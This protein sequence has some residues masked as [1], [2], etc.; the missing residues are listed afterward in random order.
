M[1]LSFL[2]IPIFRAAF[3][4]YSLL[5]LL[6]CGKLNGKPIAMH[7][8]GT[9]SGNYIVQ[10]T[11][12]GNR[13]D[14]SAQFN[15][16][17]TEL[18]RQRINTI[19]RFNMSS[20]VF[21][22][23]SLRFLAPVKFEDILGLRGVEGIWPV[24][25]NSKERGVI[26][27]IGFD[28]HSLRKRMASFDKTGVKKLHDAGITGKGVKVAI[29]DTGLD[30][31]HPA[32]G[33]QVGKGHKVEYVHDILDHTIHEPDHFLRQGPDK[34]GHGTH[35]AGIIAAQDKDIGFL[36][37][38]YEAT[39]RLYRVGGRDAYDEIGDD[40]IIRA[41]E[42][43]YD[44]GA[45]VICLTTGH[46]N[47]WGNN[48]VAVALSR[49]ASNG[50]FVSV[51]LGNSGEKGL[52]G[53]DNGA[54]A[55]HVI[56]VGAAV[57]DNYLTWEAAVIDG[58]EVRTIPVN[59]IRSTG[60]LLPPTKLLSVSRDPRSD[61]HACH[62]LDKKLDLSQY[63]VIIRIG[64]CGI[65]R[66]LTNIVARGAKAALFYNNDNPYALPDK[67]EIDRK[68]RIPCAMTTAD[69]GVWIM[70]KLN[71][72]KPL[73][74]DLVK[75]VYTGPHIK[76]SKTGGLMKMLSSWG[77]SND[78][79]I[80]P[81]IVAPGADIFST[82]PVS[83]GSYRTISGTSMAA[84]FIAGVAALYIS[85]H[86]KLKSGDDVIR[87]NNRIIASGKPIPWFDGQRVDPSRYAPVSQAGGGYIDAWQVVN[88]QTSISPGKI[89]LGTPASFDPK[90]KVQL[91]KVTIKNNGPVGAMY[92]IKHIPDYGLISI[93]GKQLSPPESRRAIAADLDIQ[94]SQFSL[95]PQESITLEL[96]FKLPP[97]EGVDHLAPIYSGRVHVIQNQQEDD[98][99]TIPYLG[100]LWNI[101]RISTLG[102]DSRFINLR[103]EKVIKENES[104]SM[105]GTDRPAVRLWL[106]W[107]SPEIKVHLVKPKWAQ[108]KSQPNYGSD[109]YVGRVDVN[110]KWI[111]RS[112][113]NFFTIKLDQWAIKS[114]NSEAKKVPSGDY[115]MVVSVLKPT[116]NPDNLAHWDIMES[117]VFTIK[118]Q[119]QNGGW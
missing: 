89:E 14:D 40:S 16:F 92:D 95:R 77:P 47:G 83:K 37:V 88:G 7:D 12:N 39:L 17:Y 87:L 63:V 109:N 80:K 98:T 108:W 114:S 84:P 60:S 113:D 1:A 8:A 117:P 21:T 49:I 45:H 76:D 52:F 70:D 101:D 102:K 54:A 13:K 112:R 72:G 28:D 32:L 35:V 48:A 106:V 79:R 69:V 43:A 53:I 4:F 33:G 78:F 20:T 73:L 10:F 110:A 56:G 59:N 93:D 66:Q 50:V 11:E 61:L 44:D 58:E 107:G 74:I 65:S 31:T 96:R 57:S 15:G 19:S 103:T 24:N 86:G 68:F 97:V 118:Y 6:H 41:A 22:A 104:F 105:K 2:R 119:S 5:L 115:K 94:R 100:I 9:V 111:H 30:Y 51:S 18:E 90:D 38:A 64:N 34:S 29:I 91:R 23:T 25:T 71:E 62:P 26:G 67:A 82:Y 81:E 85:Q 116:G 46:E 55:E 36:G 75:G 99:L 27:R 42:Q 3:L